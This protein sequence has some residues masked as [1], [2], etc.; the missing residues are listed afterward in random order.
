MCNLHILELFTSPP[1]ANSPQLAHGNW[2][3][4]LFVTRDTS[5]PVTKESLFCHQREPLFYRSGESDFFCLK[6]FAMSQ[7]RTIFAFGNG[8]EMATLGLVSSEV[9]SSCLRRAFASGGENRTRSETRQ[10][11]SATKQPD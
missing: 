8:R 9:P 4:P 6:K 5:L 2:K 10:T 11:A 3:N 7:F 1:L